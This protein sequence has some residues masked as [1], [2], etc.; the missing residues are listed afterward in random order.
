MNEIPL[1]SYFKIVPIQVTDVTFTPHIIECSSSDNNVS[2][3]IAWAANV[4]NIQYIMTNTL[5]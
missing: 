4:C 1:L 2:F 5:L 3:T